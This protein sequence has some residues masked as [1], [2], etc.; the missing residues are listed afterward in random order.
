MASVSDETI[1]LSGADCL[2]QIA[3]DVELLNF[4]GP[5]L[6]E[7]IRQAKDREQKVA[8][9]GSV[10]SVDFFTRQGEVS[11]I[12]GFV[13]D[14]GEPLGELS[15]ERDVFSGLIKQTVALRRGRELDVANSWAHLLVLKPGVGQETRVKDEGHAVDI[16]LRKQSSLPVGT[17]FLGK[18]RQFSTKPEEGGSLTIARLRGI[19]RTNLSGLVN[20]E[21]GEPRVELQI[22]DSK[23]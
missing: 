18:V 22:I 19:L 15:V 11:A 9:L 10:A 1:K 7:L 2:A 13:A 4:W 21:S 23:L 3:K 6:P 5:Q 14:M 20:Q 12:P 16:R 8:M 17:V